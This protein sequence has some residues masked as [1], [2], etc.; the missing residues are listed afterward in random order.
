V[1]G[2]KGGV[3][4]TVIAVNLAI[5]I[6]QIT[7]KPVVLVDADVQQGDVRL[8]LDID[9]AYSI[10]DLLLRADEV[11]EV[12]F[13]RTLVSHDSGIHVLA[14]PLPQVD[15]TTIVEAESF[16]KILSLMRMSFK[17]IVVDGWPAWGRYNP[18]AM[19]EADITLLVTT[20]EVTSLRRAKQFIELARSLGDPSAMPRLILNRYRSGWGRSEH[21]LDEALTEKIYASI[22]IDHTVVNES[23]NLGI[24]CIVGHRRSAFSK[25]LLA[26][27]KTISND[28]RV[29][30]GVAGPES[31]AVQS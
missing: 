23:I 18:T 14:A 17:Y 16:G 1:W 9:P 12:L 8:M 13:N 11:D 15:S 19:N 3:G 25:G 7:K 2:A 27:A 31:V 28:A 22:A 30:P 5:A 4:Q 21:Y 10:Y 29:A 20:D 24:P 6:H 26:L